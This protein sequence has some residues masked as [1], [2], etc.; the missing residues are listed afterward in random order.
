MGGDGD[1]T[2]IGGSG[3]D[4]LLGGE[5]VNLLMG[6]EGSDIFVFKNEIST[7]TILDFEAGPGVTDRINLSDHDFLEF[8]RGAQFNR[9]HR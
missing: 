8:Q 4:R 5:G 1:D 3:A 9:G 6:G 2:L 7:S